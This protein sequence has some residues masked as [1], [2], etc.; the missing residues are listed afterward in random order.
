M[1]SSTHNCCKNSAWE[2]LHVGETGVLTCMTLNSY[3]SISCYLS[4]L[5]GLGASAT[6]QC[7]I[8]QY[9]THCLQHALPEVNQAA[10]AL[11]GPAPLAT[12]QMG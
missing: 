9:H 5:A 2:A 8:S 7:M 10:Q 11:S 1:H 6:T 3:T 4:V 12:N